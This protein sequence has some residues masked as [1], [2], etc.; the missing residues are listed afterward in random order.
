MW[1]FQNIK[2]GHVGAVIGALWFSRLALCLKHFPRWRPGQARAFRYQL[3]PHSGMPLERV[4]G[5]MG[6]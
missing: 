3:V 4:L 1:D 6:F 5:G 2:G